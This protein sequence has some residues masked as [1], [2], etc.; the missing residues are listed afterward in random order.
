MRVSEMKK[1]VGKVGMFDL[2]N[3]E[4]VT[5]RVEKVTDDGYVTFK[6]LIQFQAVQVPNN[7]TEVQMIP[8]P[9]GAPICQ[10]GKNV[11]MEVTNVL[12][13]FDLPPGMEDTYNKITGSITLPSGSGL[14]IP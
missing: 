11:E 14:I 1:L 10:L 2:A 7:P 9:Y 5:S 12:F 4:R 6:Q 13:S 3:G 8:V